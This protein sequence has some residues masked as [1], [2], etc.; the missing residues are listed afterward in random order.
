MNLLKFFHLIGNITS[1][2]HRFVHFQSY[3]FESISIYKKKIILEG[4]RSD[5]KLL[6]RWLKS[7]K[8]ISPAAFEN[9]RAAYSW[10]GTLYLFWADEFDIDFVDNITAGDYLSIP[11]EHTFNC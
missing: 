4:E 10:K 6:R 5:T 8:T 3:K 9:L 11:K 1:E 7:L 2:N